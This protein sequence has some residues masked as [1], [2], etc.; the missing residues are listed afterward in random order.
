MRFDLAQK[1][2]L[3][4]DLD[5]KVRGLAGVA[6]QRVHRLA[7]AFD[8]LG[9]AQEGRAD[10]EGAA[11]DVPELARLLAFDDAVALQGDEHAVDGGDGLARCLRPVP[12]GSCRGWA[13]RASQ[14]VIARSSDCTVFWSVL[15]VKAF[16]RPRGFWAIWCA[17]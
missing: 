14:Q 13:A 16:G 9:A 17:S 1:Q 10:A 12:T 6:H 15:S 4:L 3:V 2:H 11:A 5:P 7:G 8:H